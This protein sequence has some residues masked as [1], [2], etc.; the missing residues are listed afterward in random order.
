MNWLFH[1]HE[2]HA[3]AHAIAALALVCV[4]GMTLGSVKIRGIGLGTAGVLFAG[5]VAGHFGKPVDHHTLEFVKEFG[6]ILFV[7]TI[8]LQLGPGF[9]AALRQQGLRLN[10]LA[11]AVVLLGAG[12]APLLGWLLG[13]DSAAVLGLLAGAT[14]NT[15]SLGAAQQTISTLSNVP[16]E[17][18]ALPALAYAVA[19]PAAI[20]GIIGTLLFL[21]NLFRIDVRREA[22]AFVANQH[23]RAEPL[24]RRTLVVE[25]A[26]LSGLTLGNIPGL[27][28]IGVTVTRIRKSA[29]TDVHAAT[30]VTPVQA[31]DS[32]L[33]VGT[34]AKL[35]QIQRIVGRRSDEDLVRASGHVTHRRVVV[36]NKAVLGKTVKELGL[37]HLFGVVVSRVTRADIEMTAVPSLELQFGDLVQIVGDDEGLAKAAKLLGNSTKELNETHFIPLFIG[38]FLGIVLGTM[39]IA[40]PGL[41]QPIRLGLAGGPL[42]VALLLGRVGHIGRLVWHM[43]VN[44]N[45]A[46][47]EFGIALFFASVGLGAGAQFFATVFSA[48][49]AL[50]LL[51]GL[52]VTLLPLL[53]VGIFARAILQMNYLELCGLIAGSMTDPP[54][55]AF[56]NNIAGSDAPTVAYATVYP[57]TTL[58]RIL[59]AQILALTLCG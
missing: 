1:L 6:L 37:D 23:H 32:L 40:F 56:A 19:Y 41:P 30:P 14:T 52:C 54:A 27:Q 11:V 9:V 57:L 49:G 44:A 13:L 42:I 47:R 43:P 53:A 29:E 39:P 36:T 33:V 2:T 26:N 21:K 38:I 24:E 3:V 59:C 15:P 16:P 48:S 4:L 55:L 10:T 50:W 22:D 34:R 18:T 31:G 8:G 17:R 5:I 25:N 58:L 45:L 51:A 12:L 7:F 46:F 35:D 28:E 20:P